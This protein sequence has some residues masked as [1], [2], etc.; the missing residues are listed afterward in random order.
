MAVQI[1]RPDDS[2]MRIK[3]EVG[4]DSLAMTFG[5]PVPR[6]EALTRVREFIDALTRKQ[7]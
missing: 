4:R 7:P 1:E 3:V 5:R 2:I 6:D